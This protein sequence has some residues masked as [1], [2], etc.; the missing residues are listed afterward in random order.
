MLLDA[1]MAVILRRIRK[2]HWLP[3]LLSLGVIGTVENLIVAGILG[4]LVLPVGFEDCL[5]VYVALPA[6]TLTAY[7]LMLAIKFEE[8]GRVALIATS[9]VVISLL[10]EFAFFGVYPDTFDLSGG[11]IVIIGVIVGT[12]R[13]WVEELSPQDERKETYKFLLL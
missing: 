4:V 8:A 9:G 11:F 1:F 7:F 2:V 3:L 6:T 5:L 10:L 12:L 13:K